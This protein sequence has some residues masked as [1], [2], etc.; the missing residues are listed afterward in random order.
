MPFSVPVR[1]LD[2][3]IRAVHRATDERAP[4]HLRHIHLEHDGEMFRA[5]CTNGHLLALYEWPCS[6]EPGQHMFSTEALTLLLGLL[7]QSVALGTPARSPAPPSIEPASATVDAKRE[8]IETPWGSC[9][10]PQRDAEYVPWRDVVRESPSKP[11]DATPIGRIK[12]TGPYLKRVE[13]CYAE[14]RERPLHAGLLFLFSGEKAPVRI[15]GGWG[16]CPL[17]IVLMPQKLDGESGVRL[18]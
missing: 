15:Q 5:V 4:S 10:A 9:H 6:S 13:R 3:A 16:G 17:S 18:A 8:L 2:E 11:D 12:F 7:E 14:L 1:R